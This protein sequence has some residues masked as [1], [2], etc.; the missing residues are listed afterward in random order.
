MRVFPGEVVRC[1]GLV[2]ALLVVAHHEVIL[3][4]RLAHLGEK[5]FSV[6]IFAQECL[7]AQAQSGLKFRAPV[8]SAG[9]VVLG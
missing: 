7:S 5:H 1:Q 4:S 3:P 9:N 2:R 6:A 8:S